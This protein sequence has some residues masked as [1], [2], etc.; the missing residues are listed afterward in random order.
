MAADV[1]DEDGEKAIWVLLVI[2]TFL[3]IVSL[4]VSIFNCQYII[5]CLAISY[6]LMVLLPL[7]NLK[8]VGCYFCNIGLC[9]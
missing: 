8:F 6:H 1:E 9:C 5:N 4:I 7:V 3:L 2:H